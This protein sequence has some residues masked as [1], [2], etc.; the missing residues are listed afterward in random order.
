MFAIEDEESIHFT[1]GDIGRR[2]EHTELMT[3]RLG[4][5][6]DEVDSGFSMRFYEDWKERK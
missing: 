3:S 2:L 6:G 4:L 5:W 1:G